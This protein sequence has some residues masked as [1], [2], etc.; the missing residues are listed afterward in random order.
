MV[1]D[2]RP[3]RAGEF[4]INKGGPTRGSKSTQRTRTVENP[5]G[6]FSNVNSLWK[7]HNGTTRDLGHRSDDYLQATARRFELRTRKFFPKYGTVGEAVSIA[8][9]R[10]KAGGAAATDKPLTYIPRHGR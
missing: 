5:D 9:D 8:K 10:S 2:L 4:V 7:T 1:E 3:F 6:T